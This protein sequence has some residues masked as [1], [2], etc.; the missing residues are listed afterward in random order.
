MLGF[1]PVKRYSCYFFNWWCYVIIAH[2]KHF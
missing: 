2:L 1:A